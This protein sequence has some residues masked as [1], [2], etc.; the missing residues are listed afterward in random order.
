MNLQTRTDAVRYMV[1][2]RTRYEFD[3]EVFLEPHLLRFY[4]RSS[5]RLQTLTHAL[6]ISPPPAGQAVVEECTG[7]IAQSCWFDG[8]HR[9][10]EI[11]AKFTVSLTHRNPFSF[12]IY[13]SE[14]FELPVRYEKE[15][16]ALLTPSLATSPLPDAL[17]RFVNDQKAAAKQQT[18]PFIMALTDA[19]SRHCQVVI[20]EEGPPHAPEATFRMQEG[21]CRDLAW[22]QIHLLRNV[23]IAARF[24][25]GYFYLEA[26]EPSWELHAWVEAYVPGAGWFGVDPSHGIAC[27]PGH[28]PIAASP[29]PEQTLPVSGTYRGAATS[30]LS[31][32]IMIHRFDERSTST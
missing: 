11:T 19:I 1:T 8:T 4:P 3:Q 21:S 5:A 9:L 25:S 10:L 6:S 15:C 7:S 24:V 22:L 27:A 17:I 13:P 29:F 20:R 31:H 23:G 32:Q 30:H 2:H 16:G 26:E 28:I 14:N 18:V 12:L